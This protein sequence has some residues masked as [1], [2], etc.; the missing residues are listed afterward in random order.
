MK[1]NVFIREDKMLAAFQKLTGEGAKEIDI[2]I[3]TDIIGSRD[4]A[5]EILNKVDL[6]GGGTIDYEEF[7]ALMLRQI[8]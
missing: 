4:H 5:Q 1:R 6:D 7:K 3:L 2:D 8:E